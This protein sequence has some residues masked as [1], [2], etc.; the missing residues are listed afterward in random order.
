MVMQVLPASR[1][2]RLA[3]VAALFAGG[4]SLSIFAS[5]RDLTVASCAQLADLPTKVTEDTNLFLDGSKFDCD[6]VSQYNAWARR[7][8][9]LYLWQDRLVSFVGA[10]CDRFWYRLHVHMYY[11][12]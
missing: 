4:G 8:Y 7:P 3:A 1:F 5:A 9:L 11:Y 6:E 2:Q 10:S 12:K